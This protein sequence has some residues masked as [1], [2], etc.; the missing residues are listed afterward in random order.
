[1][2]SV[3]ATI[4]W[5]RLV[6][7]IGLFASRGPS[8]TSYAAATLI[9][10]V[11]ATAS[12]AFLAHR[13]RTVGSVI[14]RFDLG[15]P[16]IRRSMLSY[17]GW[18]LLLQVASL[19]TASGPTILA[20]RLFGPEQVTRY[21]LGARWEPLLRSLLATPIATLAPL[22]TQLEATR[23]EERSRQAVRRAVAW[24]S[25]LAVPACLV[26]C[27][28]GD[29]FLARWVG[30]TYRSSS[31]YL[32]AT[33][34]P[35]TLAIATAPVWAAL[36][37]RGRIARLALGD[38]CLAIGGLIVGTGLALATGAGLL[39]FAIGV[40]L[41]ILGKAAF[42]VPMTAS[43][44]R[45]IGRKR[46]IWGPLGRALLGALPGL[47]ILF[48]LRDFYA[49]SLPAVVLAGGLGGMAALAGSAATTLGWSEIRN[50]WR[51]LRLEVP[52]R[53]PVQ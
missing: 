34:L 27:I 6:A 49:A 12:M 7:V 8:L 42:L 39:G 2:Q 50:L 52:P 21:S 9:A 40:A 13:A 4:P 31:A 30:E 17:G 24:A 51:S 46:D 20:G 1:M 41:A 38:L 14:P 28:V 15:E 3:S 36:T 32:I 29:L 44:Y 35:T 53:G 37:G 23:E 11:C 43:R 5:I 26:P 25:A 16:A 18:A 10:E 48:V 19:V 33:L 45:V 47:G 22:F